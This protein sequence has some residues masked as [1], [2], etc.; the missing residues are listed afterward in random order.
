MKIEAKIGDL[1]SLAAQA[2]RAGIT[3]SRIA[4]ALGID[5]SQVSRVLNGRVKGNSKAAEKICNYV[6]NAQTVVTREAVCN[7]E[8]LIQSLVEVWDGSDEH[9]NALA[10]VIRSLWALSPAAKIRKRK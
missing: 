1:T 5:Q 3:Q 4:G 9:A 7:N 10:N 8:K 6:K 2:K